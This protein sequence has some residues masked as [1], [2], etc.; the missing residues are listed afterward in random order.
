MSNYSNYPPGV[1]GR[2]FAISGA[3]DE[4]EDYPRG[5]CFECGWSGSEKV[6]YQSHWES[7]VWWICPKCWSG[8]DCTRQ[9]EEEREPQYD[10]ER[11][12]EENAARNERETEFGYDG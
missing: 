9:I 4:W 3:D 10:A 2:E 1:T 8:V 11:E 6:T 12:M 5:E 7:G